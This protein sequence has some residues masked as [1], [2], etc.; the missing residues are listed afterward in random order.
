MA[1]ARRGKA[2]TDMQGTLASSPFAVGAWLLIFFGPHVAPNPKLAA[3]IAARVLLPARAGGHCGG[4]ETLW[5]RD[6]GA[7][8]SLTIGR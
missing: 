2:I 3:S 1:Q 4:P 7:A 8:G 5:G 6:P